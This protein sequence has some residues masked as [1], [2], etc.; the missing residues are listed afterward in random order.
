[1]EKAPLEMAETVETAFALPLAIEDDFLVRE[2]CWL[3]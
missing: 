2:G 1:V 3:E